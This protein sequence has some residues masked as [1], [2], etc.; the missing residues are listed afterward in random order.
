LAAPVITW[1][2]CTKSGPTYSAITSLNFG[3]ITA[4]AWSVQ[5]CIR[6]KVATNSIQSAKWWFYDI[7][8]VRSA[9]SVGMGTVGG[10]RHFMTVTNTYV[11]VT[12]TTPKGSAG[13]SAAGW[14]EVPESTGSG[15]AAS[16][17]AAAAYGEFTYFSIKVPSAAGDG[18]H[19]AWGYQLKY[20]YT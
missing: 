15:V 4:G 8:G 18:A 3:T 5:Q 20:S 6:A 10:F 19:T 9:A 14:K 13:L 16:A 12:S 7:K 11:T 17:V 1:F 2:R